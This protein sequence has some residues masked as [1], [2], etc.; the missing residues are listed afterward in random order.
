MKHFYCLRCLIKGW[1]LNPHGFEYIYLKS[2]VQ[3]NDHTEAWAPP[4]GAPV[5]ERMG[6]AQ[7]G[8]LKPWCC[9]PPAWP[10]ERVEQ[11]RLIGGSDI[12]AGHEGWEV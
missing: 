10:G 5:C 12:Y 4:L 6:Q 1:L 9:G 3:G 11:G 8:V 7:R 2:W